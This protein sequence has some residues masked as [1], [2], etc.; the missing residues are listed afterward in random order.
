MTRAIGGCLVAGLTAALAVTLSGQAPAPQQQPPPPVVTTGLIVGRV[1]DAGSGRPVS[2]ATVTL[3]GGI[4]PTIPPP[5]PGAPRPFIPPQQPPRVLTDPEGRFAFRYLTRGNYNLAVAKPG[6]AEGA[7]GRMRPGGPSR[8]VQL[9]DHERVGD[10]TLRLFKYGVIAGHVTDEAGEPVVAASLRL[11]RRQLVAGRRVMQFTVTTQTDDRGAYRFGNQLPGDYF[12]V[13]PMTTVSVPVNFLVDGRDMNFQSTAN[14]PGNSTPIGA[15]GGRPLTADARFLLQSPMPQMGGGSSTAPDNVNGQLMSYPTVYYPGAT[16]PSS[17]E[18][19]TIGSGEERNGVNLRLAPVPAANISGAIISPEGSAANYVLHLVP[20]D[21]GTL[22]FDPDVAT[23][24]T[25][26]TG[27][28]SFLAVPAGQYV[29]QTTRVARPRPVTVTP[30]GNVTTMMPAVA[31]GA[32]Q[33]AEPTLWVAMPVSVGGQDIQGLTLMLRE[34]VTVSGRVEFTGINAERPTAQRLTQIP[35]AIEP[36]DGQQ[37]SNSNLQARIDGNGTFK[38]SGVL[39]GRYL[40]RSSSPPGWILHSAMAHGVD[41]A[42]VP[43]D[44]TEKDGGGIV[45]RFTDRFSQLSGTVRGTKEGDEDPAVVVFPADAQQWRNY[46]FSSRRMRMSRAPAPAGAYTVGTIPAGEYFVVAIPAEY[47]GEWQDPA[48]LEVLSR[49]ASRVSIA[50]GDQRKE[51]LDIQV[52]KPPAGGGREPRPAPSMAIESYD[53]PAEAH[54][55]FALEDQ[56]PAASPPQRDR[57]VVEKPGTGSISGVVVLDDA[58]SAP[59]RKV[60]VSVRSAELRNERTAMTDD[61]GRF[62]IPWLAPGQYNVTATKSAYLTGFHGARRPGRGPGTTVAVTA[63]QTITGVSIRMARGG[64]I[65]GTVVDQFGQPLPQAR[66]RLMQFQ[67]RDGE[68]LSVTVGGS[69]TMMTDDRGVYRVY[70]L[71]PGSYTVGIAPPSAA[72]AET[73]LLSDD[74]MRAAIADLKRPSPAPTPAT[75]AS[76]RRS[77]P[78]AP[79]GPLPVAPLSGR[80]I[81]FATVY[82]P[83]TVI[84]PDAAPIVVTAGQETSS[85]DFAMQMVPTSRVEGSVVL[86]DGSV[87][88]RV[89]MSLWSWMG[90]GGSSTSVMVM[91]DGKFQARGIAPG[92][93]ALVAQMM[94]EPQQLVDMPGAPPLPPEPPTLQYFAYHELALGGDDVT[95]LV[96]NLAAGLAISG[97]VAFE[98]KGTEPVPEPGRVRVSLE[99]VGNAGRMGLSYARAVSPDA[100]GAFRLTGVTPGRYRLNAFV[101]APVGSTAPPAWSVKSS[102]VNGANSIDV[103]FEITPGRPVDGAML[104]LT[105]QATELAGTIKTATGA[106]VSDLLI[107]LFPTD[108]TLWVSPRRMRQGIRPGTDGTYRIT[109]ILPGEYYLAAVTDIEP[110]DWGDPAYMD[111][112]AAGAI[113]LVFVEGEKKTQDLRTR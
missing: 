89:Q 31:S 14:T 45:L 41:V 40:V 20:S 113:K 13:V 37:R 58:S 86:P 76:G 82:Y 105:D 60:R 77:I 36:A 102:I 47:S 98:R 24:V 81:A 33:P 1:I 55:P 92:R 52:V 16:T 11:Y 68:R 23:A 110:G 21:T 30:G 99:P 64:V 95:G 34:G 53:A 111:Q 78:P 9:V 18:V 6:Y 96:L 61:E 107:L 84:E 88:S 50:D 57:L 3:N 63:G 75:D 46:G 19:I 103:P 7:Y 79:P 44:L 87:P 66:L 85:V 56:R 26:S 106:A 67:Y 94:S 80:A 49:V 43:L 25:D 12:V 27:S 100:N 104:T 42:D 4:T 54:G 28:F 72:T 112:V 109:N 22:S 51:D 69:G 39:P 2:G 48:Y 62:T 70:G 59:L 29:I 101:S 15:L 90:S 91:P 73:R 97:R 71:M 5:S 108:R 83:G 38:I 8:Q 93:Y 65:T 74:E 32:P 17:A 35:V 10:V